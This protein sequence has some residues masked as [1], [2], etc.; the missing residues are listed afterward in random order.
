MDRPDY[1]SLLSLSRNST[2]SP[3]IVKAAYHA[4]LLR[5]H[6]D[7]TLNPTTT[8]Q[9][10]LDMNELRVAC[11]T[12]SDARQRAAYDRLLSLLH[13]TTEGQK[14]GPRPAEVFS[15][16]D[17]KEDV[18]EERWTHPCRCGSLYQ[19]DSKQLEADVHVI[20][21]GA[22]SEVVWVGYEA[23]DEDAGS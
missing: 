2:L 9:A 15:L 20:G 16:D 3:T 11:E 4:A 14:S 12:L 8:A 17:F 18:E 22:C 13:T 7:K 21:C 1:Y 5:H 19:I 23:A 10:G 6:P